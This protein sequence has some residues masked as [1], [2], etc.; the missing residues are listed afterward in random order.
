MKRIIVGTLALCA[1]C[2]PDIQNTPPGTFVVARFDPSAAV[3]VVPTP[4]DLATNPATGLLAVTPPAGA[5][6]ADLAF[7][8]WLNTLD[9]FPAVATATATFTATLDPA[10]VSASTVRVLDL[11][12]SNAVVIVTSTASETTSTDAP[13]LLAISPPTGGWLAG[14]RYALAIVGGAN[15]MKGKGGVTVVGSPTWALLRVGSSLVTCEDLASPTCKPSTEIIPS[16]VKGDDV[17]RLADQTKSALQLEALRRKYA[18]AVNAVIA[19]GVAREDLALLWTFKVASS[20]TFVFNPAGS[21]PAVPTPT[22]LVL[23]NGI[24]HAPI[25][26]TSSPANQEFTADYLNTLNGFPPSA[27]AVANVAGGDL[28]PAS[29][30]SAAFK[31]I[32]LAG[33]ALSGAPTF[34]WDATKKTITV[35][36][37]GGSW[38]RNKTIA[39]AALAGVAGGLKGSTGKALTAS[40]AWA[41]ARSASTLVDCT[42]LTS[43]ACKSVITAAPVT[44]AQAVGLEAVRRGYK[45]VLDALTAL[46]AKRANVVGLWVFTTVNQPEATFDLAAATPIIPFPSNQFLRTADDINGTAH[47]AFPPMPGPAAALFAG[48]NTLDGFSTTAPIVS[49]NS[50]TKGAIDEGTL[51]AN[52]LDGG[53]GFAKLEGAGLLT[54]NVK[55]CLNCTSSS[56]GATAPPEQLQWVPQRPL[57][58]LSRYAAWVTTD[59]KDSTGRAVAPSSTFA[60]VRL[61]NPLID[62]NNKS[63]LSVVSDAQAGQLEPYR[64]KFKDCLD[65][66]EAQGVPRK[67]IALGFCVTTQSTTSVLRLLSLAVGQIPAATLPD[68]PTMLVDV[69]APT[70]AQMD[71][72]L[73]PRG[74]L[75]KIFAGTMIV[76]FGLSSTT[77]TLIPNPAMWGARKIP[78]TLYFPA[79]CAAG[80]CPVTFFGHGLGR[81]RNDSL[82][83]ANAIAGGGMASVAIDVVYHGDRSTCVGSKAATMQASDDAAC[84][85]PATQTCDASTGRCVARD[86]TT[87]PTACNPAGNGDAVCFAAGKGQ[88]QISGPNAGKCEGGDFLRNA[89]GEVR[90][91]AWNFLDLVNL[92]ATRDNFRYT[93]SIDFATLVRLLKSSAPTSLAAQLALNSAPAL[94]T[95]TI[96]YVGQSL[97]SFNGS[98]F[99]ASSPVANNVA[100]NVP[101]SSQVDVLLNAPAFAAQRTGFLGGLAA[102]GLTPG[103]PGFDQ[104]I[105]IARTILDPADPQNLI[106]DAVNS[107]NT[108]RKIYFQSIE[109]DPVLPNA[110]TDLLT[111]AAE[112]NPVRPIQKFRFTVGGGITA[113]F[114]IP[115]RHGFMLSTTGNPDCNPL[116]ASCATVVAQTKVTTFL[117][118]GVAP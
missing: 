62:A 93:G 98:V 48:L 26:P 42:D 63:T 24:V 45:P 60:L 35:T 87:A 5:S 3:P 97:G 70:K 31:V 12:A 92:F 57:E 102:L 85:D 66:I 74:N 106:Y 33:G 59:V 58:A 100:L 34:A 7:Y 115:N 116:T 104:F 44:N 110:T 28:D 71:A 23:V 89:S 107:S 79:A 43:T 69:T 94:D 18:P 64:L 76:P 105:V 37:A 77:G 41:L 39:I 22:N 68:S 17:K 96:N 56:G 29:V 38:G 90:I 50:D 32:P 95:T 61:K 27:A 10:T 19:T 109:G 99:A 2:S 52:S 67:K 88:C 78:F 55:V 101:G 81:N 36:P 49:E 112:Q 6:G 11:D 21:P 9:G 25:D 46:G 118:T 20:P 103:T 40:D 111:Q 75:G 15:G 14:H 117:A 82:A 51:D 54:P 47:L 16:N 113:A 4:N 1:A 83:I 8:E 80:G 108:N 65:K 114:P 73:I 86:Q 30:S 53:V 13:G 72:L 84:A 91:S